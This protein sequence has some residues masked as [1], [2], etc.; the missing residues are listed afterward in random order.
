MRV[1]TRMSESSD[2]P[3]PLASDS[4]DSSSPEPS[5][6]SASPVSPPV[7]RVWRGISTARPSHRA[8]RQA[9]AARPSRA[10]V[11]RHTSQSRVRVTAPSHPSE[12]RV[13][14]L[15][16]HL[17]RSGNWPPPPA[18]SPR[19]LPSAPAPCPCPPRPT[20]VA[21]GNRLCRGR[22]R[23]GGG[24]GTA[25]TARMRRLQRAPVSARR[26]ALPT[27][28]LR[29]HINHQPVI[30]AMFSSLSFSDGAAR[31]PLTRSA[32]P[33]VPLRRGCATAD[34]AGPTL[35]LPPTPPVAT[36]RLG[37]AACPC[38]RS[39]LPA[40]LP[41]PYP[42]RASAANALACLADAATVP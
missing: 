2:S 27:E 41:C 28:P 4:S 32:S 8:K 33:T 31:A 19:R 40:P 30:C 37:P 7:A 11:S 39:P 9:R 26:S 34:G 21:G 1:A 12:S 25:I 20:A 15:L 38:P 29:R 17:V 10:S 3:S 18:I 24:G 42:T 36:R 6:S 5:E 23:T 13:P 22:R 14:A 35:V 16:T